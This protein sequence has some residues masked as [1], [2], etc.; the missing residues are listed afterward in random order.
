[1]AVPQLYRGLGIQINSHC[2]ENYRNWEG[3]NSRDEPEPEDLLDPII[4]EVFLFLALLL[5]FNLVFFS[6]IRK[7]G[8]LGY[9]YQRLMVKGF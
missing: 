8:Y 3:C 1:V 2:S 6:N 9:N 7:T 5:K 4:P